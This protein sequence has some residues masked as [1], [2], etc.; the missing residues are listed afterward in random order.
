MM[1]FRPFSP[2]HLL[3]VAGLALALAALVA[4]G[5]AARRNGSVRR[6]DVAAGTVILAFWAV[7]NAYAVVRW[8]FTWRNSL[9]LQVCDVTALSAALVF[10]TAKRL[11]QTI[12]YFWGIALSTQGIVTPDLA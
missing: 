11:P 2:L 6:F 10:L 8:G 9:P 4:G 5:L 1:D 3:T 12:S 7:Y